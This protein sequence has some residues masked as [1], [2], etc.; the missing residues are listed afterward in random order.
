MYSQFPPVSAARSTTIDPNFMDS[1][2]S[3]VINLGA[4]F[5]GISAVVITISTSLHYLANNFISAS[6][7]S[8]D[9]TLAYP[10]TPAPSSP[11]NYNSKKSAPTDLT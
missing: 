1:T 10:P 9:I 8:L 3:L 6:I 4:G 5:P 11:S 7:N 2:I